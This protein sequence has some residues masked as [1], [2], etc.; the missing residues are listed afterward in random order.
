MP[1]RSYDDWPEY[2]PRLPAD[3][4]KAK[5]RRGEFGTTWWSKRWIEALE[6]FGYGS[7]LIRGRTYARS[8]AVL[9]IDINPG[10]ASARVQGSQVTPYKITIGVTRLDDA[11]WAQVIDVMAEQA[12]FTAKLLVGEMPP[13]I[14]SAFEAANVPLFPATIA[15]LTTR[16]SCA[17]WTNPCKH[18]AAVYYLLGERFDE[19]PFLLFTLRGRTK[20]QIIEALR[21]RRADAFTN[22][23][24]VAVVETAPPLADLLATYD[25]PGAALAQIVP[26]IAAPELEAVILRRFGDPPAGIAET[27]RTVQRMVTRAVLERL[28]AV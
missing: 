1:R 5:N 15:D 19:D 13:A 17:D 4:I 20:A 14:E 25:E 2:R 28:F 18:I 7:R 6:C 22:D 9:H 10:K 3:G 8:G 27:L 12:L 21:V 26:H 11:Q 24:V 23:T 16:C